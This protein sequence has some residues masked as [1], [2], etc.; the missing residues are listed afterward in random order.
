M[1]YL[2]PLGC[3]AILAWPAV[4]MSSGSAPIL[5]SGASPLV[6]GNSPNAQAVKVQE[7]ALAV[8]VEIRLQKSTSV[9]S[10]VIVHRHGNLYTLITN[11]HVVCG[12][13]LCAK[14]PSAE[15]YLLTTVDGQKYVVPVQGVKLLGKNLDLAMVQFR[16]SRNYEVAKVA[17]PDSLRTDDIVYAAGFPATQKAFIVSEGAAVAVVN[18]RLRDDD[19]GY[20]TIYN[21]KTLPGM[22]G[23][24][25]FDRQGRLVAIHG[26]GDRYREKTQDSDTGARYITTDAGILA[27]RTHRAKVGSK[28]GY[29]RGIPIRWLVAGL[30]EQNIFLGTK[31]RPNLVSG[32][33]G[34][35]AVTADE[36]FIAGFNAWVN[37]GAQGSV[38][39]KQ[40]ASQLSRAIQLNPRYV[41]AYFSRAAIYEQIGEYTKS[42]ADYDQVLSLTP[43]DADAYSNRGFLKSERLNDLQGGLADL[44]RAIAIN[45]RV[46]HFYYNRANLKTLQK[47]SAGALLDYSQAIALDPESYAAYNNRG[48]LKE[49]QLGDTPGALQDYSRAIAINPRQPAAYLNRASL[50]TDR[51][52][53]FAGAL[54]DYDQAIAVDPEY[55]DAYY[56][57]ANLKSQNLKDFAGALADYDRAIAINPRF[58]LAYHNRS[59][60]KSSHLG[61]LSGALADLNM[62]IAIDP[63]DSKA[64]SLRGLL[65]TEHLADPQ[66]ALADLN[67]AIQLDS[68]NATAYGSRGILKATQ[69][70]DPQGA[71]ADY[72]RAI[73]LD[74]KKFN[75]YNN[76]GFLKADLLQDFPGALA[77]YDR[78]IELNP[79]YRRA[80]LNRAILKADKLG[81]LRGA[82]ADYNKLIAI[83]PNYAYAYYRRGLLRKDRLA[84]R[85]GAIQDFRTAIKLDRQQGNK[86]EL[87]DSIEQLRSLGVTE[88]L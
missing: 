52:K 10:G 59:Q 83:A 74:P 36:F 12:G 45:P 67:R 72:N 76:R 87:D 30:T 55:A 68:L 53:D 78:A 81:D 41:A 82:L 8:S 71:L 73:Q 37:P 79:D 42:L 7:I 19:G 84:D 88:A 43:N 13:R 14:L 20:T 66:G 1:K 35:E 48:L 6:I 75:V 21:A 18:K 24:G 26:Q 77:D 38:G 86:E 65:K 40:A 85:A 15:K 3:T 54:T 44:N 63:K 57:R 16:S 9:G 80:Y 29:N 25:V 23:G 34:A 33:N 28:I 69:L 61:D 58:L 5:S 47:D 2:I 60:L 32:D 64:F 56:N 49:T 27:P 62:A 70:N 4:A 50:K 11:R 17:N 31:G 51:L 46:A 39:R 22:S